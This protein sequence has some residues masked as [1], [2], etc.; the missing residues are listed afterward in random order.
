MATANV[1]L[2]FSQVIIKILVASVAFQRFI[3]I[4]D[5]NV[6]Q[7]VEKGISLETVNSQ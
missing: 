7:T 5:W 2:D 1:P 4:R 3:D 6:Q